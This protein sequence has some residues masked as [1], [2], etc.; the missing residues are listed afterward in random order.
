LCGATEKVF[1]NALRQVPATNVIFRRSRDYRRLN[2]SEKKAIVESKPC[3]EETI[4]IIAPEVILLISNGAYELFA[5]HYCA[6]VK[7]DQDEQILT[8]NGRYPACLFQ[9]ATARVMVVGRDVRLV[10]VAH[11]SKYDWLWRI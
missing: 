11:P 5:K 8:P 9:F 2:V 1:G 7:E 3:L 4:H 10:C 6:A